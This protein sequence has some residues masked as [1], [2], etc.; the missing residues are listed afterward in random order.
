MV[1]YTVRKNSSYL[2]AKEDT[3]IDSA[4]VPC[5]TLIRFGLKGTLQPV[6]PS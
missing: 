2:A 5:D 3:S 4:V 1:V 6:A